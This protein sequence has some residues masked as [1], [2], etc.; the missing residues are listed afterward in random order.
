[1]TELGGILNRLE[2]LVAEITPG[3]SPKQVSA[4]AL[5][6]VNGWIALTAEERRAL[7]ESILIGT[8]E[9]SHEL[10]DR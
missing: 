2:Q 4:K 8:E 10:Q 6:F 7:I 9:I 1:M 5:A 3:L